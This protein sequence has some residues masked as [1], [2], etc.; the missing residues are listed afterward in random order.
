MQ[1]RKTA[2]DVI[3]YCENA[4]RAYVESCRKKEKQ[5]NKIIDVI[6]QEL[7]QL[8]DASFED[9]VKFVYQY[10]KK[11]DKNSDLHQDLFNALRTAL[12]IH[13]SISSRPITVSM[14]VERE[15]MEKQ[16][17]EERMKQLDAGE[18]QPLLRRF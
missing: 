14:Y 17:L 6:S 13:V 9:A 7:A 2:K 12:N 18:K 15:R 16:M 3:T 8:A 4:I 10:Y 5:P 1:A 11:V